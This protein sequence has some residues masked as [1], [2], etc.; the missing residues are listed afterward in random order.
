MVTQWPGTDARLFALMSSG[1]AVLAQNAGRSVE[2]KPAM[3]G[4]R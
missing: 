3:A 2:Q 1:F 4:W